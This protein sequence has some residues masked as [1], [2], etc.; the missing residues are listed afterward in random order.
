[1]E[2]PKLYYE[3]RGSGGP[4]LLLVHGL[5]SSRTQW[6][7]NVEALSKFCRPVIVELF[8]HGRSPT[9]EDPRFYAPDYYVLEFERIRNELNAGHWFVCGQSLGASLTLRYGLKHPEH[10]VA[11]VFTNSRSAFSDESWDGVMKVLQERLAKEGRS[12]IDN[13]PL[14]PSR[15]KRLAPDIKRAMVKDVDLINVEGFGNTLIYTLAQCSVR[16]MLKKNRVPTLMI[17]GRHDKTFAPFLDIAKEIMPDLEVRVLDGGHAVN[18]DAAPEF[19]TAVQDFISRHQ[20]HG[21]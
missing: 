9:P 17:V 5:L 13:F 19:N 21:M 10:I 15:S 12:V 18:I 16:N 3:V 6:M 8:G 4:F 2:K 20:I 11:Q 7:A 14:H 1:M